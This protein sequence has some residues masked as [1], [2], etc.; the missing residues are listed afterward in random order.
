MAI[1]SY[2]ALAKRPTHTKTGHLR[3]C[4]EIT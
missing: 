3:A 1:Q 2:S 4:H